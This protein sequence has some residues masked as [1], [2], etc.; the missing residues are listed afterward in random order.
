M[1]SIQGCSWTG[2]PGSSREFFL[3]RE[4]EGDIKECNI[5]ILCQ[6]VCFHIYLSNGQNKQTLQIYNFF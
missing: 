1:Q 3:Y 2:V 4:Y 5:V 6:W